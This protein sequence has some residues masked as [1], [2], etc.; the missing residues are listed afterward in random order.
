MVWHD[1]RHSKSIWEQIH[2]TGVVGC[3][4][5]IQPTTNINGLSKGYLNDNIQSVNTQVHF[6]NL[7]TKKYSLCDTR[8]MAGPSLKVILSVSVLIV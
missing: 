3:K 5:I 2:F 8:N 4:A 1:E 7:Y 6:V